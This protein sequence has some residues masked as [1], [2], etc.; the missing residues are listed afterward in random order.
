MAGVRQEQLGTQAHVPTTDRLDTASNVSKSGAHTGN[1]STEYDVTGN[2][3]GLTIHRNGDCKPTKDACKYQQY[4]YEWDEVGRLMRARRFDSPNTGND[5]P[6]AEL[7]F[8]YDSGNN[9][10]RKTSGSSH[11]IY[12]FD[13]LELRSAQFDG[14]AYEVTEA[15]EVPFVFAHGVRLGRVVH[16]SATETRLYMELGDHLGSTSV[17][18]DHDSGQLVERNTA[19]AYGAPESIYRSNVDPEFREDY[20]FTGK[21]DDIEVGLIYFGQRYYA[22]L[23]QRWL[24]PDPLAV[25]APGKADLNVYAYVHGKVLIAVDPVGLRDDTNLGNWDKSAE[26]APL[27][28]GDLKGILSSATRAGQRMGVDVEVLARAQQG[29]VN[30]GIGSCDGKPCYDPETNT[31]LLRQSEWQSLRHLAAGTVTDNGVASAADYRAVGR[32][33][34]TVSHEATHWW[35]ANTAEGKAGVEQVR[36]QAMKDGVTFEGQN[37]WNTSSIS[38]SDLGEAKSYAQEVIA[39]AVGR[40]VLASYVGHHLSHKGEGA[41]AGWYAGAMNRGSRGEWVLGYVAADSSVSGKTVF[42]DSPASATAR[43]IIKQLTPQAESWAT[44]MLQAVP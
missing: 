18:L 30:L 25:H 1:L 32:A 16:K 20:R 22:P 38:Q 35:E 41:A 12:V 40:R 19:Y 34:G 43:T 36:D 4:K 31:I 6:A 21:E 23:L 29:D 27:A 13:S 15:T 39:D 9:R 11:T 3:T 44:Q 28:E 26:E 24:S 5:P 2:L 17:V 33:L 14:A 10:V 42:A 37:R 7:S 8:S